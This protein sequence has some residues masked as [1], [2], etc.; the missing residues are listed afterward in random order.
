VVGEAM[1]GLWRVAQDDA[2]MADLRTPLAARATC[3]AG[4]AIDAQTDATEARTHPDPDRVRG[5]WFRD[6]ET[7]MDDQQHAIS[8]LLRTIAIVETAPGESG[9][10]EPSPSAW[11][12]FAALVAGW[13]PFRGALGVPRRGGTRRT[14]EVAALGAAGGAI[15]VVL[16]ALTATWLFDALDVS[17]PAA[18]IA[19]GAVAA[20]AGAAD[21][22]RRPPRPDPS[23]PGWRAAL[24]PVAVPLTIRPA[25]LL[26]ALSARADVGPAPVGTALAVGAALLVALVAGLAAASGPAE[27]ATDGG[28][29]GVGGAA[30]AG[31]AGGRAV[32]WAGRV[33]AAVL[34]AVSAVL[35]VDGVLDV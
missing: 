12:W 21:L 9:S 11:L 26:L 20:V 2:R 22:L 28:V 18:R 30:G 5:A 33:T 7:R 13:N 4:L 15:V 25:L 34:V 14:A 24:V 8:A 6:G 27:E 10:S 35:I 19:A 32:R 29:A 17:D 16:V 31:G 3:I 1:T 23:L